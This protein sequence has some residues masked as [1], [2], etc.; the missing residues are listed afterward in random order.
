MLEGCAK[1]LEFLCDEDYAISS[2]CDLTRNT[3]IDRLVKKCEQDYENYVTLMAAVRINLV[4]KFFFHVLHTNLCVFI[5]RRAQ[6]RCGV[7]AGI[8]F[9]KNCLILVTSQSWDMEFV[10][11]SV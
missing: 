4:C 11:F 7:Y 1:A 2:R 10:G 5:G 8:G 3:L 6:Q 9:E